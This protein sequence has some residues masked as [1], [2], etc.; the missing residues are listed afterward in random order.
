VLYRAITRTGFF[1]L[2]TFYLWAGTIHVVQEGD[3]LFRI[4]KRY[5]VEVNEIQKANPT[6]SAEKI[7]AGQKIVI[8]E[9]EIDFFDDDL[10]D[11]QVVK[12]ELKY[13]HIVQSGE[14]LS[15][16]AKRNHVSIESIKKINGLKTNQIIAGQKLALNEE[17]L[18]NSDPNVIPET[19]IFSDELED[20]LEEQVEKKPSD[21]KVEKGTNFSFKKDGKIDK[22]KEEINKIVP[23]EKNIKKEVEKLKELKLES[24]SKASLQVRDQKT[25]HHKNNK[26]TL[27]STEEKS[28]SLPEYFF[29]APV[30]RQIDAPKKLRN[31]KYIVVHHSGTKSGNAKIFNYYHSKVRGMEN[32]LAYHFVIGNGTD[33]EDGEIEVGERWLEQLQGGHLASEYLNEI[34]IGICF[35]G[36]FSGSQPTRKQIAS[37]VELINY[38]N[39]KIKTGRPQFKLHREINTR[40]TECPGKFFPAQAMHKL[41]G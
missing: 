37:L 38:L 12:K 32:G 16:I 36:D 39:S 30:K 41:F 17:G 18:G 7:K 26:E 5:K 23:E 22:K 11:P 40:P 29:V 1:F 31:W 25:G 35:V 4:G 33:S 2:L 34:S 20:D 15:K 8:P 6:V 21:K 24:K 28:N 13:N 10:L 27:K 14:T 9:K 3:T 19:K